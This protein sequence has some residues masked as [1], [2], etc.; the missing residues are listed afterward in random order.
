MSSNK[1][2][3]VAVAH[4][5][6]ISIVDGKK[7]SGF[8]VELWEKVAEEIKV[9]YK[10]SKSKFL[11]IFEKL[12]KQKV[13]VAIAGITKTAK[14]EETIDFSHNTFNSGLA[15]LVNKKKSW[16]LFR[17]MGIVF[18]KSMRSVLL[19]LLLFVVVAANV[20]WLAEKGSTNIDN[21]YIPGVFEALWWSIVTV[22]TV[23]YGDFVPGT[24]LGRFVGSVVI[25]S[26][27]AIFGLYI[28]KVSSAITLRELRSDITDKK[29]L[30]GKLVATKK[31]TTS[32]DALKEVGATVVEVEDIEETYEKL[33]KSKVDAVVFDAPILYE[34][35]NGDY[36]QKFS[37]VDNLFMKQPYGFGLI[38]GSN[39]REPINRALLKL[40][41][42]GVYRD[43]Y[44]KWFGEQKYF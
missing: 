19:I 20:L 12:E 25:L 40:K 4:F 18:N 41:E 6:P 16:N 32:V 26:G 2:I 37:L 34:V 5:S 30:K 17:F 9:E 31:G 3:K 43:L 39:L 38:E 33:E 8:E 14:R 28:A 21:S 7:F 1:K 44:V 11:D 15:I 27:L 13:D 29:D 23:G 35:I 22:S 36:L 42:N 10:Y 24:W